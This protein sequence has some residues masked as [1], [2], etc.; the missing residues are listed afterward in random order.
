MN[1]Y[2]VTFH[3]Y[4][5]SDA[6]VQ[7]LRRALYDLVSSLYGEGIYVTA[8]KLTRAVRMLGKSSVLK[9]YLK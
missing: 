4:A 5:E 3:L 9:Q 8:E 7:E 6:E 2:P 1:P